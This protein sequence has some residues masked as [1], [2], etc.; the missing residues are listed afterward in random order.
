MG[1]GVLLIAIVTAISCSVVGVFLILRKMSMMT[2]AISH[3]VL[4]GIVLAFLIVPTLDSPLLIIGAVLMG[5]IT[6]ALTEAL[7]NTKK[8]KEDAATGVVFPLLFS[9]AIIIIS[10]FINNIHMDVDAVLLG[11][12]E[13]SA[14]EQLVVFGV[15]IGP[16]LLYISL[17]VLIINLVF[18]KLF[19]KELKIVSFD[20]ALATVLG[21]SPIIIHYLLMALVSLTAVTAFSAVGSILVV[22]LMI[23][24]GATAMQF[25]KDLKYTLLWSAI[26]AIINSVL[27]YFLAIIINVTISGV[28]ASTTLITFILVLLFNTKNGIVFKVA[29]R[30]KQKEEFDFIILLMHVY[31]H[32]GTKKENIELN[33]DNIHHELNWSLSK[34]NHF[35]NLGLRKNYFVENDNLIK[36]TNLGKDYH[37]FKVNELSN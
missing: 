16:K 8:I 22:A 14:I 2:D 33:L 12:L 32:E 29:R 1:L 37:D 24:P 4:L 7:V 28:I 34:V 21:F 11:K 6:V 5:L 23:G 15:N 18:I 35:V 17:L 10:L 31:N 3:T 9:I 36:L 19:Y 20:T 13:L 27:G 30:R 25:T 26:I